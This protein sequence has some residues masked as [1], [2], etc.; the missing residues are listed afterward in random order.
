MMAGGG[1]D[2]LE[3]IVELNNIN[4]KDNKRGCSSKRAFAKSARKSPFWGARLKDVTK[5]K[6]GI[7]KHV[8]N[9]KAVKKF[10]YKGQALSDDFFAA[11]AQ[12]AFDEA[13]VLREIRYQVP[14]WMINDFPDTADENIKNMHNIWWTT[15][16]HAGATSE[17]LSH[18]SRVVSVAQLA[19]PTSSSTWAA[20]W[21]DMKAVS[22]RTDKVNALKRLIAIIQEDLTGDRMPEKE[23]DAMDEALTFL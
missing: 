14:S 19:L 13:T 2:C 7:E 15:R 21:A 20:M 10:L 3:S 22:E 4:V 5:Y 12:Q 23:V 9:M 1:V 8:P 11:T 6:G 16:G 17:E 18:W